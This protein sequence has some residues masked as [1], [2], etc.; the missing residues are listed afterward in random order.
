MP[1]KFYEIYIGVNFITV[2][3]RKLCPLQ[4]NYSHNFRQYADSRINYAEMFYEIG[5]GVNFRKDFCH[6]LCPFGII[7]VKTLGSMLTAA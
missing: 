2:F 4:H 5:P 3:C 1:K 7:I 6:K